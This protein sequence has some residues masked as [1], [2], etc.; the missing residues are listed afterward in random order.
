[1][2]PA[3]SFLAVYQVVFFI[4]ANSIPTSYFVVV[5]YSKTVGAVRKGD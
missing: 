3:L 4:T 5:L 2:M 1:M